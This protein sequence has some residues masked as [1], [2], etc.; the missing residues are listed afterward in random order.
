MSF[1]ET[2]LSKVKWKGYLTVRKHSLWRN[3]LAWGLLAQAGRFKSMT[4]G[5]LH[6]LTE[7][8]ASLTFSGDVG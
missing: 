1:E 3:R 2:Q 8:S 6:T 5:R 7:N 4:S